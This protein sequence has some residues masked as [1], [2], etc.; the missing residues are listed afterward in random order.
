MQFAGVRR[1]FAQIVAFRILLGDGRAALARALGDVVDERASDAAQIDALVRV[2]RAVLG[3]DDR[4]A[5]VVGQYRAVDD[6]AV[7]FGERAHL[8]GAVVE[9]DGRVLR[10]RDLLRGGDLRGDVEIGE[11]AD[12]CGEPRRDQPEHPFEDEMPA[13]S[14]ELR[15]LAALDAMV[16][17]PVMTG[18]GFAL[19][20]APDVP[21]RT[22]SAVT[23]M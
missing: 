9:V 13:A 5:H 20:R 22:S 19:R 7:L 3:G 11:C 4:V 8:G 2:E 12:A 1:G 10:Q 21:A 18:G 14:L 6:V 17:A 15:P 16:A 23:R